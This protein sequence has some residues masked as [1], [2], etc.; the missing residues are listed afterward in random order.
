MSNSDAALACPVCG[1]QGRKV[2]QETLEHHLERSSRAKFGAEAGFCPNT[3]CEV[4]Y[5]GDGYLHL[6]APRT[7]RLSAQL[8]F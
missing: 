2:G 8:D 3:A 6:G 7:F 4:V 5:F 1:K